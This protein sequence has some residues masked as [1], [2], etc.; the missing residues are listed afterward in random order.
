MSSDA[1]KENVFQ[2]DMIKQFVANGWLP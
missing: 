1:T 2:N